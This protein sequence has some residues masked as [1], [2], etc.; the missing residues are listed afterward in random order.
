[1]KSIAF[2]VL[3]A[4]LLF[5]VFGRNQSR[6]LTVRQHIQNVAV[7][8]RSASSSGI[9][10]GALFEEQASPEKSPK[11]APLEF[12]DSDFAQNIREAQAEQV[13]I[14]NPLIRKLLDLNQED[15]RATLLKLQ[16][17]LKYFTGRLIF[18]IYL[19]SAAIP[20]LMVFTRKTSF[21]GKGLLFAQM[22]FDAGRLL[23]VVVAVVSLVL[24]FTLKYNLL[25]DIGL[26]F[27]LG[28]FALLVSSAISLKLYDW[29]SPVWNRMFVAAVWPAAS[30]LIVRLL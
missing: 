15:I 7:K 19:L 25:L 13:L 9:G 24:W 18:P 17:Q 2:I 29:N 12:D 30:S 8:Y 20:V 16:R 26:I 6:P 28:L 27:L 10:R 22:G 4:V 23:L 5:A 1:M 14:I 21:S 11:Q 3:V